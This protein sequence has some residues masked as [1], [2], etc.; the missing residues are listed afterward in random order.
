MQLYR[1]STKYTLNAKNIIIV[2]SVI[3]PASTRYVP[4][5]ISATLPTSLHICAAWD[6]YIF[7]RSP[8]NIRL[9]T[10]TSLLRQILIRTV[11][12]P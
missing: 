12:L 1:R 6:E 3:E 7:K 11:S 5:E 4:V 9:V 10:S 2:P 8:P